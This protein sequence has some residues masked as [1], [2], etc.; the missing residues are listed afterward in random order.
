M[1]IQ[2][3]DGP[4]FDDPTDQAPILIVVDNRIVRLTART[5]RARIA[6]YLLRG[7]VE[8]CVRVR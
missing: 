3:T 2:I 7:Y 5:W 1:R 4:S 6:F 8:R